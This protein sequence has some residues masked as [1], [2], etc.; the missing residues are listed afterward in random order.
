MLSPDHC[1]PAKETSR[2]VKLSRS[3]KRIAIRQDCHDTRA[4]RSTRQSPSNMP[5]CNAP[6]PEKGGTKKSCLGRSSTRTDAAAE[7]E[8]WEYR[9]SLQTASCTCSRE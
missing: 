9:L 7:R 1:L 4:Q 5:A 2:E 3:G 6:L 8:I